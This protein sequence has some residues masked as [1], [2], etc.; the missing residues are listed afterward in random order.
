MNKLLESPEILDVPEV[1]AE[2]ATEHK[3]ALAKRL[4]ERL[5]NIHIKPPAPRP[6]FLHWSD[7]DLYGRESHNHFGPTQK[8]ENIMGGRDGR[9]GN[10]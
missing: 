7:P 8:C 6:T 4:A 10:H 2:P 1:A 9:I 5:F 3:E